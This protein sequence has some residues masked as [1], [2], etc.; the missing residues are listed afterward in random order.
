MR[1]GGFHR[2]LPG[3]PLTT[4]TDGKQPCAVDPELFFAHTAHEVRLAAEACHSCPFRN[5]CRLE[6]L[7]ND[8]RGVWGGLSARGRTLLGQA[9]RLAEIERLRNLLAQES[10][11]NVRPQEQEMVA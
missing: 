6:G 11:Q 4:K 3:R 5:P 7:E 2:Q 10:Q 1:R 9:G 8:E